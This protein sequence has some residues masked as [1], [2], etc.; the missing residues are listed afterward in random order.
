MLWYPQYSTLNGTHYLVAALKSVDS[1]NDNIEYAIGCID[2]VIGVIDN[3]TSFIDSVIGRI[4]S[5]FQC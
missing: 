4:K 1:V 5:D 2:T 3:V